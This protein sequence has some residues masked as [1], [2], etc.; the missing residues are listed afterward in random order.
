MQSHVLSDSSNRTTV[1]GDAY[2]RT[3]N[4]CSCRVTSL[5]IFPSLFRC[6]SWPWALFDSVRSPSLERWN[7]VCEIYAY[8]TF[9]FNGTWNFLPSLEPVSCIVRRYPSRVW[10]TDMISPSDSCTEF[11]EH[12]LVRFYERYDDTTYTRVT[13]LRK[14]YWKFCEA[15]G[16]SRVK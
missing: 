5:H 7:V 9:P 10:S 4:I 16:S 13:F 8:N 2:T 15:G 12:V 11:A 14:K 3:T 1:N 6:M